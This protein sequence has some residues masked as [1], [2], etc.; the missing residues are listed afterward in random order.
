[1]LEIL[2]SPPHV[3]AF[4]F[5]GTLT[6]ADYDRCI[7]ELEARL[8]GYRRIGLYVDLTGFTGLTAEALGKDLRYALGKFGEYHRF[9]RGAV[10][11]ERE[12]MARVSEFAGVFFPGTEIRAFA[13]GERAEA[14]AWAADVPAER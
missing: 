14:M 13:P 12:W 11:T 8:G 2:P 10:I 3:A 6:G 4:H 1:M 9:A 7:A 5:T